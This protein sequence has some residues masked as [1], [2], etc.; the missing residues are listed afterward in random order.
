MKPNG[1]FY[2]S[3]DGGPSGSYP[4]RPQARAQE[5]AARGPAADEVPGGPR[6]SGK[7]RPRAR[8]PP[9]IEASEFE[10]LGKDGPQRPAN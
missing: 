2:I 5:N 6:S 1:V 7:R 10:A 4:P 3:L 9:L 8:P